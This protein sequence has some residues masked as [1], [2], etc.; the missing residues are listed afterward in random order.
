[1]IRDS[2]VPAGAPAVTDAPPDI[3]I[4]VNRK[5]RIITKL[6]QVFEEISGFEVDPAD[7]QITFLELGLDSLSLTQ[8]AQQLQKTFAVKVTFRELMEDLSSLGRLATFL[9]ERMA[10]DP[11]S[12]AAPVAAAP[13]AVRIAELG[14][15]S[16]VATSEV[17]S[18]GG[19]PPVSGGAMQSDV[20]KQ[21]IDQQLAIMQQQ[22]ALLTAATIGAPAAAVAAQ[23]AGA[24]GNPVG[25][26][27]A[28][29]AH[30]NGR[31]NG[32][33]TG[34]SNGSA[35]ADVGAAMSRG[36]SLTAA[37]ASEAGPAPLSPYALPDE[38]QLEAVLK[39][40]FGAI[41][42]INKTKSDDLTSDQRARLSAFM[43]RYIKRTQRSKDFTQQH[44]THLS[45]PRAVTGFRPQLK[46]MVY[47][48]VMERSAG[49]HMWDL[50]GNEYVDTL[51][52][53]GCS[54]FGWQPEF[55]SDAAIEQIHRG[56]EIGPMT[57]LA[58]EVA[59]LLCEMTGNDRAAFC[60][61]GSE[62]V[63]GC[64]RIARTVTGR[65]TI[66]IFNGSYHGIFDEVIVRGTKKLRSVP[67]APGILPSTAQNVL[68]LEYGDPAALDILRARGHELAAIMVEP[69]QSRRPDLQPKEFLHELRKIA[70]ECGAVYIF[71]EVITGFR[72][73]PGGAQAY[74]DVKADLASYGKVIGGGYPFAVI[75]GKSQYM[76]ALDGGFWQYGDDSVPTVGVTY[77]AGTFCRH[78]LA[79]NVAKAVLQH[80]KH[81][82]PQLQEHLNA[83][84]AEL[85]TAL[86]AFFA[87]VGAPLEVRYFASLWKVFWLEEQPYGDLLFYYMRDKGIHILDMFPCFLT[88][89]HSDADLAAIVA[90]FRESVT[91]LQAGGF[92]PGT[93]A[94]VA[95]VAGTAASSEAPP[96]SGARLGRD[97]QGN[98]AWF[99]PDPVNPAR[100]VR[101]ASV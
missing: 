48:V 15:A 96:V 78:P 19:V 100:F 55:A 18:A 23:P 9:D 58:A 80:L 98:P 30:E 81:A 28:S 41:A 90:A 89:A 45:D 69:V 79:L 77:F 94:A 68:I 75:A 84:T 95:A 32:N 12:V 71:D 53:F 16:A 2:N 37:H 46:E 91:E 3:A 7:E 57:P 97:Q 72:C 62:A 21:T 26:S 4:T 38:S 34:S 59:E 85:A 40:G 10:P 29:H 51:S 61:T 70:D 27:A 31:A 73:H 5:P 54:L 56:H 36:E 87:S 82:G 74:F 50:D 13:A 76:D 24:V 67:A 83:K 49:S 93:T 86:N 35:H 22:L 60:N 8:V 99:V 25:H 65:D 66:A 17:H 43:R 101:V 44:R 39:K 11:V 63:M 20:I 1:L 33:A 64:M 88:T 47:Q 52:G 14:A 42:R 92:L 6:S